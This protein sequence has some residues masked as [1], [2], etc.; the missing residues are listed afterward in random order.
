M[1]VLFVLWTGVIGVGL[2]RGLTGNNLR[3]VT[4]N[5]VTDD[6]IMIHIFI[7]ILALIFHFH[8][9]CSEFQPLTFYRHGYKRVPVNQN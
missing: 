4:F 5:T 9:F 3:T 8:V 7:F 6:F 1:D 2:L